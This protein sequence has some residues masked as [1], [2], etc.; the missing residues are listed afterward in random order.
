MI[1]FIN[2]SA[3][4]D[5]ICIYPFKKILTKI[6]L[7][8]GR[9]RWW[10]ALGMSCVLCPAPACS[11]PLIWTNM[12]VMFRS[13]WRALLALSNSEDLPRPDHTSYPQI[14]HLSSSRNKKAWVKTAVPQAKQFWFDTV[15]WNGEL[16]CLFTF[17][18]PN[19]Q[20]KTISYRRNVLW[21]SFQLRVSHKKYLVISPIEAKLDWRC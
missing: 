21:W 14:Y 11:V 17:H 1:K 19:Q 5:Q 8:W 9:Q 13:K 2:N 16:F 7:E 18:R 3:S 4:K 12:A 20:K 10:T 15:S 6:F